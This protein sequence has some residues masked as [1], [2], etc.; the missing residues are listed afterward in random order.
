[1]DEKKLIQTKSAVGRAGAS[2]GI[3][4]ANWGYLIFLK[5]V[6]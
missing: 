4:V 2:N 3:Q 5:N 1:M 6:F